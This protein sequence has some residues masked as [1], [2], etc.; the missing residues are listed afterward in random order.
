MNPFGPSYAGL[1]GSGTSSHLGL[2]RI[3]DPDLKIADVQALVNTAN[4]GG[5]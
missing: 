4:I 5:E 1:G 3:F 2:E